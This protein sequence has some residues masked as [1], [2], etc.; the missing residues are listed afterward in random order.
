M[1]TLHEL[2]AELRWAS[3]NIFSTQDH[4]AAAI[5]KAR[6]SNVFAWKGET[7]EEY[8]D[9]TNKML[10]WPD[11]DGPD[12]L[13]DDGVMLP[14]LFT[15]VLRLRD[16]SPRLESFQTLTPLITWNSNRSFVSSEEVFKLVLPKNGPK[17]QRN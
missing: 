1:G 16:T 9:C 3:C 7:L 11:C 14:Y 12:I 10:T 15:K 5:V 8:W 6:T 17:C 13:V 4:A 2:G